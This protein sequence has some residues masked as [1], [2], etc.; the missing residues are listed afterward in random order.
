MRAAFYKD[1]RQR[2]RRRRW[3]FSLRDLARRLKRGRDPSLANLR[4]F[5]TKYSTDYRRQ[6]ARR[7]DGRID[8]CMHAHI[9]TYMRG[10]M[11]RLVAAC[12]FIIAY[13]YLRVI[14]DGVRAPPSRD[15]RHDGGGWTSARERYIYLRP[16]A[17][18]YRVGCSLLTSCTKP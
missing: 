2:R 3:W 14:L 1:I 11:D 12:R 7:T 15:R 13:V 18:T 9:H 10:W 4:W 6:A 5:R 17:S 8:G 16:F